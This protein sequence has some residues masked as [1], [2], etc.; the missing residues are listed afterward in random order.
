MRKKKAPKRYVQP[1][2][3]FGDVMVSQFVNRLM[4]QGKK[5]V[6]YEIFYDSIDLVEE[7]TKENGLEVW[8][9]AIQNVGPSVEVRTRRVGGSN[10][11]IPTEVRGDRKAAVAM[12][13]IIQYSRERNGKSMSDKLASEIVAASKGE[14][15]AFK[16]K[17]DTHKMA[18]AN[19][20]FAHFRF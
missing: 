14:G 1:D 3:K 6:A 13:W 16:K 20:A 18:E 11:Q 17:E 12:K 9:K 4:W 15:S 8:K 7:K 5:S 10:Y 19:K 2:P